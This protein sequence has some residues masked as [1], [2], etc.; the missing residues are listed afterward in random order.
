MIKMDGADILL[1]SRYSGTVGLILISVCLVV[2]YIVKIV[3]LM[4]N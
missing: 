1:P 2:V 4:Q 3:K